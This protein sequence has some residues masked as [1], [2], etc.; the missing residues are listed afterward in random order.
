MFYL[1]KNLKYINFL[2]YLKFNISTTPK[3]LIHI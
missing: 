1:N 3:Y 2:K